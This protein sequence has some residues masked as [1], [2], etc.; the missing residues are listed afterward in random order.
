M[1]DKPVR[2]AGVRAQAFWGITKVEGGA[3]VTGCGGVLVQL[4][5]VPVQAAGVGGVTERGLVAGHGV[6]GGGAP[7]LRW[8]ELAGAVRPAVLIQVV[9]EPVQRPCGGR[10]AAEPVSAVAGRRVPGRAGADAGQWPPGTLARDGGEGHGLFQP[11]LA[12]GVPLGI[13]QV[14]RRGGFQERLRQARPHAQAAG[15]HR[16][17]DQRRRGGRGVAVPGQQLRR[18]GQE[19]DHLPV[20]FG[21]S[22]G[23]S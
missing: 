5:S 2:G 14:P 17:I 18:P 11:V 23:E 16:G 15:I 8:R 3:E 21:R 22:C 7:E 1:R 12:E 10:H 19:L 6:R 9:R 13:G 4:D 20:F